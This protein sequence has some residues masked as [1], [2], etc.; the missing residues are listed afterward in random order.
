MD[1]DRNLR[2]RDGAEAAARA[3]PLFSL[4]VFFAEIDRAISSLIHSTG[5]DDQMLRTDMDTQ[6]AV[7]TRLRINLNVTC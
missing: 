4:Y 3:L 6:P 2:T 5:R 7:L 1:L